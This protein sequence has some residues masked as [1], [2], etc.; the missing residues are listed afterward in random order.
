[1]LFWKRSLFLEID[2][3]AC[4]KEGHFLKTIGKV[5]WEKKGTRQKKTPQ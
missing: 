1:M 3:P 4:R 5:R 2:Q